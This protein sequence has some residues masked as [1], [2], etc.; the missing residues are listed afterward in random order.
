MTL[1]EQYRQHAAIQREAAA[2]TN[3][4]NR[5][6]MHERSALM[7]EQMALD[8]ELTAERTRVNAEDKARRTA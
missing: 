2:A 6:A 8:A 7:W 3:L 5:Q 4:P 1:L